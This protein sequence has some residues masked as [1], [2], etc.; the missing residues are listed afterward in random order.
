MP[1]PHVTPDLAF[2]VTSD[3]RVLLV[4]GRLAES[5]VRNVAESLNQQG[6]KRYEVAVAGI[7]VAA[8]MHTDWLRRKLKV[9][10]V[11]DC[12]ILPGWC[13]GDI[14]E[15]AAAWSVTVELGPKEISELP[16]FLG[17]KEPTAPDLSRYDIEIIAEINHAP[18]LSD[19]EIVTI[20][21]GYR[22]DGA[23]VID[24][25]GIP[26]QP[27][28]R[29]GEIV[30]LLKTEGHRVSIDSFNR[31]EVEAA[32]TAGAEL[33]L[34]ANSSNIAWAGDL[35]VEWV[36]IP[37]DPRELT[38]LWKSAT[39][40]KE[41]HRPVRLDPI[42]EPIGYHFAASLAR[43]YEVR[44]KE[45]GTPMMMGI[46]N[47]TELTAVDSAGVN[48]LLA[49]ICQ[50]LGIH[51]VLTTQVI[52][53]CRTAVKEFDRARRL[54]RHAI[55]QQTLPKR[56]S[57]D[58]VMLR[59]PRLSE[60][61]ESSLVELSRQLRDPN[62]RIFVERDEIHVMNRDGYWRGTDP[63]ELFDEFSKDADLD[64]SHAFYLG[65]ELAKAITALTLGKQY[66]QDQALRW[67][68]LTVPE[69]SIHDRRRSGRKG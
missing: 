18:L 58:L 47:V 22:D 6:T 31:S 39:R 51:S 43:Y 19:A 66:R 63:F 15:L 45:P 38:G 12:V 61:G 55:A 46:G 53:W 60:L 26:G 14:G 2:D 32:V 36:V 68:L 65:Y 37:D 17:G 54:V 59:D 52:P 41:S 9:E 3:S 21:S 1:K 49:A 57:D 30:R 50:E 10:P 33:V 29:I 24:V 48:F 16:A 64:A 8:L 35:D 28:A 67:G 5:L 4:T 23:D 11:Y 56:L 13:Q 40:L 44:R 25:G 27:F 42:L 20:A 34:S 69:M 7:S 62:F